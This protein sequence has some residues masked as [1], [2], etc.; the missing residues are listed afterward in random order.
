MSASPERP[1]LDRLRDTL[2]GA[3][4][5]EVGPLDV[6]DACRRY[7]EAGYE[8]TPRLREFLE[9][10]GELTVTWMFRQWEVELTTSVEQA[11]DMPVRSAR[12]YAKRIGEPVLPVG[13]TSSTEDWVLLAENGDI[14][15]AGDAGVQRVANG[16]APSLQALITGDWD[17]TFF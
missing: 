5:F 13:V 12:I 7:A 1:E 2:T 10:Y 4:R 17:M 9:N 6:E 3:Q 8:V 14:L 15:I 11:L 16:F